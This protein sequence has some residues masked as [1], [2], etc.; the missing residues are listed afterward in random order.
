[1]LRGDVADQLLD[2]DGLT[3]TGTAEDRGL[4]TLEERAD[5]VDDLHARLEDLRLRRLVGERRRGTVDRVAAIAFHGALAVDRLADDVEEPAERRLADRHGDRPAGGDRLHPAAQA[6]GRGHRDRA[7]PVVSEVLLHLG[8]HF[9]AVL[10]LDDERVVDLGEVALFEL[11]V[12]DRADDLDDPSG[13]RRLF[14]GGFFRR[15]GHLSLPL[16]EGL[17]PRCDLEHLF[18]DS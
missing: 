14:L 6:V 16:P 10:A 17:G 8:D 9:A 13:V 5:E 1:M 12:E 11:D 2:D 18:G 15:Y 3:G 7:H 4:A